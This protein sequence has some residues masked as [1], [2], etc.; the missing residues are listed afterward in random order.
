MKW[1]TSNP[2]KA[3]GVL[4]QTG[5]IEAGKD[6]DIVL[7]THNPFSVYARAQQV[8]IDG[9]VAYDM[10]DPKKQP[11]TDFDLGIINPQINRVQ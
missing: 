1:I 3:A 7:W 10:N 2:A 11:V 9:A 8:L 4:D 6:A 5:S